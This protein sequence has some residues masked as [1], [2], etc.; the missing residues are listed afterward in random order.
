[1]HSTKHPIAIEDSVATLNL[2]SFHYGAP[3]SGKKVYIQAAIH[4][5]EVPAMLVA[6]LLRGQLDKLDAEGKI[7]G[8]IILV[9]AANPLG[10]SQV[11][12][13]AP[14]GRYDLSTGLNFNRSY[15]H[16]AAALKDALAGRLGADAAA[17]VALIRELAR[18][19]VAAWEP[20]DNAATLKK[21]LLGMAI[22]A[23][24]VLDLHC[25][26][27]AVLH[28]Y[29][30]TP[31]VDVIQPLADLMGARV[32]LVAKESG[33]EA[34]DEACSRVWWDLAD[35]FI[36]AAIPPACAAV[37]V[38]LRGENDVNYDYA[39]QDADAILQYL[40]HVGVLDIPANALPA[41]HCG[42]TQLDAVEPLVAP[43]AG[44]L[45]FRKKLGD[46]VAAGEPIADVVNPVSGQVTPVA[47]S[48]AGLLFASTAHRHLLRGMHICKVAG[49]DSFRLGNLLSS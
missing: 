30:G 5:D 47:A 22:D 39:Q 21:I 31:L 46:R 4:A 37:T 19:E 34:F 24:I 6:H 14:F 11:M 25:D 45:V 2:T 18:N 17:N 32:L 26:N 49:T 43:H 13:G 35:H 29:T 10:L 41:A 44:V 12:H 23:D 9:P 28:M 36:D 16:V 40:A 15:R 27:E 38:E 33:G 48:R 20:A 8:E 7:K 42:P 1:M 3:G